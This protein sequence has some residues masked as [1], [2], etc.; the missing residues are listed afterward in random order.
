[1][2][3]VTGPTTESTMRNCQGCGDMRLTRFVVFRRNTGMLIARRTHRIAGNLCKACIRRYFW[4]F[5]LKNLVYGP[6]GL[7][8]FFVTPIYLIRNATTYVVASHKLRGAL[9]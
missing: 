3:T 1:M 2:A 5:E 6:W 7:I 4:N 8:S 9:E